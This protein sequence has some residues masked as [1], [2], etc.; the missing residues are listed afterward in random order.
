MKESEYGCRY[1]VLLS[2]PYFNPIRML[3]IDPMQTLFLYVAKHFLSNVLISKNLLLASHFNLIQN[4]VDR[5]RVPAGLGRIP[6]KIESGFSAFTADQFKNWVLY[7]SVLALRGILINADMEC[8]KHFVLACRFLCSKEITK[9]SLQLASVL[10]VKF[11]QRCEKQYGEDIITPSMHMMCHL[12]ECVLDFGPLHE[13]WLFPFE[14]F[15]GVLGKIPN[16]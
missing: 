3:A 4:R 10:L 11:S 8:W 1:S 2:L 12:H 7:Y 5:I 6:T 15:N 16:L 9:E 14:R 13:F